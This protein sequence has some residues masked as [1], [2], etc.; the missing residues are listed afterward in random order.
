VS[1]SNRPD[2]GEWGCGLSSRSVEADMDEMQVQKVCQEATKA[3]TCG[4]SRG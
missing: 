4:A 1:L 3:P 2:R